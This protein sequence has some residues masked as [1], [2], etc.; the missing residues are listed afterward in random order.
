ML[1]LFGN[2]VGLGW[3]SG[4]HRIDHDVR[5]IPAT[6]EVTLPAFAPNAP[7]NPYFSVALGISTAT[8]GRRDSGIGAPVVVVPPRENH[9]WNDGGLLLGFGG[10]VRF[11]AAGG[12]K[13]VVDARAYVRGSPRFTSVQAGLGLRP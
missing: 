1:W 6:F 2:G 5:V 13:V 3:Q 9:E 8:G 4:Y 10:G 11:P 12:F 7:V